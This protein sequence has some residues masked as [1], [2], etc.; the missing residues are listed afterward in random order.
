MPRPQ[1]YPGEKRE[2]FRSFMTP[3]RWQQMARYGMGENVAFP[4][5]QELIYKQNVTDKENLFLEEFLGELFKQQDKKRLG[6]AGKTKLYGDS[7][8]EEAKG[9]AGR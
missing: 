9:L 3:E 2:L 1:D 6:L 4:T 5:H 7:Q 8:L